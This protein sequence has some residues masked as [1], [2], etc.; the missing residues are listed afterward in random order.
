MNS[1]NTLAVEKA[2]FE[3][4]KETLVKE[5]GVGKYAVFIGA[6]LLGVFANYRDALVQGYSSSENGSFLVR[7]ISLH[8]EAVCVASPVE[9]Q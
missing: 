1:T 6:M 9:V 3:K 4:E 2:A 8:D 7:K 5:Y